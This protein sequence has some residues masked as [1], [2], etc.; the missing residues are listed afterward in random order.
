MSDMLKGFLI[1]VGLSIAIIIIISVIFGAL[2]LLDEPGIIITERWNTIDVYSI[3]GG[4]EQ[5]IFCYLDDNNTYNEIILY[6]EQ[7]FKTL[8]EKLGVNYDNKENNE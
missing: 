1:G 6:D 7:R 2:G 4:G 3:A 8:L 5:F